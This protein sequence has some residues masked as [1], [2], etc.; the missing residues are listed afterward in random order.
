VKCDFYPMAIHPNTASMLKESASEMLHVAEYCINYR[1]DAQWEANQVGGCLG[2]PAAVMLFSL[3]DM[4]GSFHEGDQTLQISINGQMK[5]IASDGY[6]HFF[7]LNSHYY[8]LA[9][10]EDQIKIVYKNFRSKLVHNLAM[11]P[12]HT[13]SIGENE[14]KSFEFQANNT[15][16]NLKPFFDISKTAVSAFIQNVDTIVPSSRQGINLNS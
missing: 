5:T 2:Y 12:E 14:T 11:P 13:L 16:V 15:R 10:T 8:E 9:L 7:I 6:Q 3:V 1:K 4:I